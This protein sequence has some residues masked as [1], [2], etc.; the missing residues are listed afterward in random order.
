MYVQDIWKIFYIEEIRIE[1]YIT[2]NILKQ[3]RLDL[4]VH[5]IGVLSS[6]YK[7]MHKIIYENNK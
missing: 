4:K 1:N 7:R 3:K 5:I 2:K 6:C